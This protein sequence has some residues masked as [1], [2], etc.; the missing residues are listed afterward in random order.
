MK[1]RNFIKTFGGLFAG[2]GLAIGGE[3]PG[4]DE[5]KE[6]DLGSPPNYLRRFE[7]IEKE[8]H[9]ALPLYRPGDIIKTKKGSIC[10]ITEANT[11]INGTTVEWND[12]LPDIINHGDFPSYSVDP[13]DPKNFSEKNAWWH[14]DEWIGVIKGS[15]H[16]TKVMK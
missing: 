13:I 12:D 3:V 6:E 10:V 15:L 5:I 7:P 11:T 2:L 4:S 1:R 9:C 16:M 14:S 8:Q